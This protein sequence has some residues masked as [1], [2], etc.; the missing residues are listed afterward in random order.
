M[1]FFAFEIEG[2]DR[3]STTL[4]VMR[5]RDYRVGLAWRAP[6]AGAP[7]LSVRLQAP[8]RDGPEGG[9]LEAKGSVSVEG[10]FDPRLTVTGNAE[11]SVRDSATTY[12]TPGVSG[13]AC[14]SL[15]ARGSRFRVEPRHASRVFGRWRSSEVGLR[16]EASYGLWSGPY[17]GPMRPYV[18]L[19]RHSSDGSLRR[20][21]GI[22]LRDTSASKVNIEIHDQSRDRFRALS[23]NTSPPLLRWPHQAVRRRGPSRTRVVRVQV[24][25]DAGALLKERK[26]VRNTFKNMAITAA[27]A[28]ATPALAQ[29][30]SRE[31]GERWRD[32]EAAPKWSSSRLHLHHGVPRNGGGAV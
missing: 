15:R 16:G 31:L 7:S 26:M 20:A 27:F 23:F 1:E 5:G 32:C 28:L 10:V 25:E 17:F 6:I 3:I 22:D 21:L 19:I 11:G 29:D 14:A 9:Q 30:A 18:G 2:G 12:M 4:P 24:M 13:G 8:D